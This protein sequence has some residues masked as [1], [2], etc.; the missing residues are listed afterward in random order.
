MDTKL[1][2]GV[3]VFL[4]ND[5]GKYLLLKRNR[6]K[7]PEIEDSWDIVGGRI[8]PGSDLLG[9]LKREVMEETRLEII[10]APVLIAAQDILPPNKH[11][12]RLTYLACAG[13][14]EP[15]LDQEEHTEYKWL[16]LHELK[17][18]PD[19]DIYAKEVLDKGLLNSV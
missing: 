1:Q 7:Y 18:H 15:V 12:V 5:D 16:T 4:K 13:S 9:N 14:G 17:N 6:G 2:V 10:S 11:V 3:K 8:N 19:L